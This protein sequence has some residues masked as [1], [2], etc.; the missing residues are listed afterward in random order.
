[1]SDLEARFMIES[2]LEGSRRAYSLTQKGQKVVQAFNSF[3][4][5]LGVDADLVP[6]AWAGLD[7]H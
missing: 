7:V 3:Q 5:E 4:G 1:L 6:Q 2:R